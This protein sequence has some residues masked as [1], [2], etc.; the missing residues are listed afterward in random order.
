MIA[1]LGV[2]S[3]THNTARSTQLSQVMKCLGVETNENGARLLTEHFSAVVK[4]EENVS[5]NYV[6]K[7]SPIKSAQAI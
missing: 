7:D 6:A 3:G 5:K 4:T 2:T 1:Y